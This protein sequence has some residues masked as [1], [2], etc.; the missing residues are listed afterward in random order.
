MPRI[1]CH[2]DGCIHLE[3]GFCSADAVELDPEMGCL[4]FTQEETENLSEDVEEEDWDA[5]LLEEE[6]E[7]EEWEDIDDLDD[8]EDE[9]DDEDE[10]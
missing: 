9:L 1:R 2:Y 3:A 5:D 8:D 4:T 6:E 10:W 7:E